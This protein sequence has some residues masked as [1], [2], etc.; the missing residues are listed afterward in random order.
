MMVEDRIEGI[1]ELAKP[2]REG[3]RVK[4]MAGYTPSFVN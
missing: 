1:K 4:Y 2:I 3:L